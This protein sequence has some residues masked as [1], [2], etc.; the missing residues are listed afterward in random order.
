MTPKRPV[1]RIACIGEVMIE[2][3]AEGAAA[4]RLG[5]AGDTFNTAVYL[6]RTLQGR[7]VEV[8][9]VTALG[10]DPWS[11]RIMSA[12]KGHGLNAA[13]VERRAGGA[14]GL[15]AIDTDERGERSFTYWRARSAARTMFSP[16]S[17]LTP[18]LLDDFDLVV[19]SGITLAILTPEAREA[20]LSWTAEFEKAG[21]RVAYDGNYRPALWEDPAVAR[22][23]AA[24]VWAASNVAL[25]SL[26]DELALH[27]DI[28]EGAVLAR[29]R[30]SGA[31]SGA[32]KRGAAGPLDLATGRAPAGLAKPAK[33]VDTTAA[34]DSFNAGYLAAHAMGA[35]DETALRAGHELALK[36][37]AARGAII[38]ET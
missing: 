16:V 13:L 28:D 18:S 23:V 10:R 37:I 7:G 3:I 27:S 2:L 29:L 32:L 21:G 25:P 4:A 35:D 26:D 17:A 6:A 5:V 8:A 22:A 12:L 15:Y 9:Y 38:D 19:F 20:L 1:R 31:T 14:P 24:R 30:R 34:G 33:V 11:D 36:V